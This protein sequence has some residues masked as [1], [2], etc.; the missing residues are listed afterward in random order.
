MSKFNIK[1]NI[2]EDPEMRAYIK[3][4]IYNQITAIAREEIKAAV[5]QKINDIPELSKNTIVDL[6]NNKIDK[7]LREGLD[8]EYCPN[9]GTTFSDRKSHN[10][11]VEA[12]VCYSQRYINK[13]LNE[14]LPSINTDVILD[15]ILEKYKIGL[16]K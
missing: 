3:E 4:I 7:N 2:E 1:V 14:I 8:T 6:V 9:Y 12:V 13:Q 5:L 16:K 15:K 11:T 10:S